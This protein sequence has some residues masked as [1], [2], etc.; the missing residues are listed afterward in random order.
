MKLKWVTN[1]N[2]R[3]LPSTYLY[4]NVYCKSIKR[5]ILIS[6]VDINMAYYDLSDSEISNQYTFPNIIGKPFQ[7]SNDNDYNSEKLT[8][9]GMVG[10]Y[11]ILDDCSTETEHIFTLDE[12]KL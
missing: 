6:T 1:H 11:K 4:N 5:D 8:R 3:S 9:M 12:I 10:V 2:R 7:T